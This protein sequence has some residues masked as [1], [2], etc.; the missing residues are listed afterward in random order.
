MDLRKFSSFPDVFKS[1]MSKLSS[2]FLLDLRIASREAENKAIGELTSKLTMLPFWVLV[3]DRETEGEW[4]W[5]NGETLDYE[6]WH[7]S[8]PNDWGGQEDCA[9]LN[10]AGHPRWN[11]IPCDDRFGFIC[12]TGAPPS[13]IQ[14][15]EATDDPV[16]DTGS[17]SPDH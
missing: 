6:P 1:A 14:P 10:W 2:E 17:D 7:E 13:A 8:E 9:A 15:E 16:L 5:P 3:T 11:D 4:Q 12:E